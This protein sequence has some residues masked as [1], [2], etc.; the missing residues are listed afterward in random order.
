MAH[1]HIR[2]GRLDD[3]EHLHRDKPFTEILKL[4]GYL[5]P[6]QRDANAFGPG[7]FIVKHDD[8]LPGRNLPS[9]EEDMPPYS[10]CP[11]PYRWMLEDHFRDI[12]EDENL[13]I[14]GRTNPNSTSTWVMEDDRQR[15]LLKHFWG[16]LVKG[17]SLVFYYCNRGN[18]VDDSVNRLLV[19]VSRIIDIGEPKYFGTRKDRPGSFPVWSR[20][21]TNGLPTHG[22][23][24]P[25]Q[26]YIALGKDTE[27]IVCRPP[28]GLM[29]PFSYVA[30][31]VSDGQAVSAMLAIMKSIEQVKTDGFV[32]G[33][34]EDAI[35]WCNSI[36]DEV[37]SGRG[38]Y[39]GLG[40]VLRYLG[41]SRAHAYQATKL[42]ELERSSKDPWKL[43]L[44]ILQGREDPPADQ[45]REGL[46]VA[47]NQWR[48]IPSRHSLLETLTHFELSTEQVTGVANE[49]LR[50]KRDIFATAANII[51]NPYLLFEQDRGGQNSEPIGLETIDQGMWPE[52][53]AALFRT[54]QPVAH[55]DRRRVRATAYA[56][57][58]EAANND[59]HTLLPFEAFIKAVHN[60]FP[61][62]RRCL[63]DREAILAGE[64]RKFYEM[65]LWLKDEPYPDTW[66]T[67][68][69]TEEFPSDID[70]ELIEDLGA[71]DEDGVEDATPTIMLVALK[72]VRRQEVEI[73][74][75]VSENVR[76]LSVKELP[77]WRSLLTQDVDKG[78]FG[79]PQTP[80]E[81]DAIE[82]KVR[83]LEV[84]YSQRVS[85]LT[86]GAGTGKTSVLRVF[87]EQL[88]SIEGVTATLL[89]APTGKARVRLQA[90]T[91]RPSNTIHQVLNDAEMLVENYRILDK[92]P[93]HGKII[94]RNIVIDESSMPSVE[95]L[96]ALFRA[97]DT[98]AFQRLIFVGD[99]FQL[100]PIGPGRPF[101]DILRWMSEEHPEC[102]AELKTCMRVT[103]TSSGETSFSRG[104]ELASGYRD[105]S[106]PGDDSVLSE[107]VKAGQLVDI[108]I[109]FWKD[110]ADLLE[111]IGEVLKSEFGIFGNDQ[112]AFDRSL[113]IEAEEWQL[114][115]N[116]QILSPT[117]IQPFGTDELNRVIQDRFR[118]E[119]LNVA[120][121][122]RSV[123]PAPM[124]D[125]EIVFH[126]KVMQR[127]NQPKWLP[128]GSSGLGFVA[129][130][131]IGVIVQ[132]RKGKN[133]K[134]DYADVVF[135]TQA[136]ATYRYNMIAVK[137]VLELAYALTVH[138][139]QG[140]DFETVILVIP[141]KAQ[142]LSRELLYTG[143]TR[144]KR[145]LVLL[146]EKDSKP[147]LNFR[148]PEAS[149]TMRRTTRM[150]KLLIG[151][152]A[153]EIGI[154]RSYR[155]E[156]LIHRTANGTAVRSKSEV[157]VYDVLDSLGLSIEY[158]EP[159][160]GKKRDQK[161][162]RLPDF[163]V[164]HKG[165]TWY[166]EHLGM[167]EK[168][169]YRDDWA[170]KIRWY[171]AN[172]YW[173]QVITSEDHP[174][175]IGG[176]VYAD[177]IRDTA[178]K[179]IVGK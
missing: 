145:K 131:E 151:H 54:E 40:S 41:F 95:L 84:L 17:K 129:N 175:G 121:D 87:L 117:R 128:K 59:G 5:P 160:L 86:G 69:S 98:N 161:D 146:V 31:H 39:P 16:K 148:R 165:Q 111:K 91:K 92:K 108:Q 130:G 7:A 53:N 122:P 132:A 97:V 173:D 96:A 126:D 153:Q 137:E 147:L 26:E 136:E 37:W 141:Q 33:A 51:K 18:A 47:A 25:Y 149:D 99:P 67:S 56:V 74:K 68:V 155:P 100:P 107:L 73:A 70:D 57:L 171:Q 52:G 88:R 102:I 109:S 63:V 58:R 12:C 140:S 150:F 152:D 19:G 163:T 134:P 125:Q 172:G 38:A 77:N 72:S 35:S 55:N 114:C 167:L 135:S 110:H 156:G 66:R 28:N 44:S 158:E 105:E 78:G 34:W 48:L 112:K 168:A 166:W 75:V 142:T 83:A 9:V 179:R 11:T 2:E 123:W 127:Q 143:L 10:S 79:E 174:G 154:K 1:E 64:D 169:K 89:A 106:G 24:I 93:E 43:V 133:Q 178:G 30:E 61:D 120:R 115:E 60:R 20:R 80:R 42:A 157:I 65:I 81:N 13:Q 82:E 46:L 170:D 45:Y 36:L 23:R 15:A 8:P 4:T 22:V 113:G 101:V 6:C 3:L 32:S 104:L 103:E 159:L 49:D 50:E 144:F 177:E 139:A 90:A 14:R 27:G 76:G 138:K 94:Y 85:I 164:H 124:G 162:F 116:W 176:I 62:K 118:S 71:K 119:M 29:Q 21:V